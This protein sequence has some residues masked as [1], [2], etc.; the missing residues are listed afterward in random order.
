M[1]MILAK[2]KEDPKLILKHLKKL[3]IPKNLKKYNSFYLIIPEEF[4]RIRELFMT[5]FDE[6]FG[7]KISGRVFTIE[8]TKHAKTVVSSEKELFISFGIKNKLFGKHRLFVPLQKD[9]KYASMM[10][11]AYYIIGFIQKQ[12]PQYF[13]NN[14]EKY[15][16]EASKIFKKE[17]KPIVE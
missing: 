12:H 11:T 1:G 14:I 4:D 17:I 9:A 13:K 2:T 10:A 15:T 16:R 8:Q 5:K 7:P 3:K 6:L